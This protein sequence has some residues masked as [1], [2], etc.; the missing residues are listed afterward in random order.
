[1]ATKRLIIINRYKGKRDNIKMP[2]V[3]WPS[4][5]SGLN[6]PSVKTLRRLPCALNGVTT[7]KPS[8]K[9]YD[10]RIKLHSLRSVSGG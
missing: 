8:L 4:M 5:N 6:R 3:A 2:P 1:M 9:I 10:S 7:E